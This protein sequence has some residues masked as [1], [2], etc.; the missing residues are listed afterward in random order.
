MY[1]STVTVRIFL[2]LYCIQ[3][4]LQLVMRYLKYFYKFKVQVLRKLIEFNAENILIFDVLVNFLYLLRI[5][6]LNF[7]YILENYIFKSND[8]SH[9]LRQQLFLTTRF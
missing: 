3:E 8:K 9:S 1:V 5:L 7:T 4:Y 2:Y 6:F